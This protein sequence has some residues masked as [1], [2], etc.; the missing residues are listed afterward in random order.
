MTNNKIFFF[1]NTDHYHEVF[2][3]KTAAAHRGPRDDRPTFYWFSDSYHSHFPA[4]DKYIYLFVKNPKEDN[5]QFRPRHLEPSFD[6]MYKDYL[7]FLAEKEKPSSERNSQEFCEPP[8]LMS[9]SDIVPDLI[10]LYDEENTAH[11]IIKPEKYKGLVF[12]LFDERE[13]PIPFNQIK[14]IV[15]VL[16]KIKES[17]PFI[18]PKKIDGVYVYDDFNG[19]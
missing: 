14:T 11:I 3:L 13:V 8:I 15:K 16:P 1:H 19:Y 18:S 7:N 2:T 4:M 17:F 10:A 9:Y 5:I 6:A 12:R